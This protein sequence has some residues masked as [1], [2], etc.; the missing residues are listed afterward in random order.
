VAVQNQESNDETARGGSHGPTA[1]ST[2]SC[3]S[4][5]TLLEG[6]RDRTVTK[7]A[8]T[9]RHPER[10]VRVRLATRAC[11]RPGL[12]RL[13]SATAFSAASAARST[14]RGPRCMPVATFRGQ[15]RGRV[16][17]IMQVAG[18]R[19]A[20]IR[21]RI[22]LGRTG[23]LATLIGR[24]IDL[25]PVG[26]LDRYG[27]GSGQRKS[28]GGRN[29]STPRG[30][31]SIDSSRCALAAESSGFDYR[32]RPREPGRRGCG[33]ESAQSCPAGSA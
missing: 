9:P 10:H 30:A 26:L 8:S 5:V 17:R 23:S 31:P 11:D 21:E 33:H 24:S 3:G 16:G 12:H 20:S 1:G 7:G 2:R 28:R 4:D 13:I 32:P 27:G 22:C 15:A 6:Y 18:Y 29:A 14:M 19:P 25:S